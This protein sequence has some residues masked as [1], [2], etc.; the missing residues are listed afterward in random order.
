[1]IGYVTRTDQT[2]PF[3]IPGQD[4]DIHSM[5]FV[6]VPNP[7]W[8]GVNLAQKNIRRDYRF[9]A[10]SR[11]AYLE[12]A[13]GNRTALAGGGNNRNVITSTVPATMPA[14]DYQVV[15]VDDGT[16]AE[17]VMGVTLT[18][19]TA[20]DVGLRPNGGS[21]AVHRVAGPA[22]YPAT[23]IQDAID[24]AAPGDLVLVPPGS[25]EELVVMWKP[26]RLQ[27][28]G[29]GEVYLNARQFPAEKIT[30][31]RNKVANLL[32][33]GS[34]DQLLGQA[35]G[36]PGFPALTEA[37]FPTEEGAAIFVAGKETGPNRFGRL[38]N[39]FARIDGMTLLGAS[40]GGG[41]IVNGYAQFL[42]IANNR[43]MG[44]AGSFGGGIRVGHPTL[45]HPENGV[46]V[47]DDA[48]N[49]N[50]RIHHN[51]VVKN[52]SFVGDG[53]GISLYTG[54][55][56]YRVQD[57]MICGNYT[58]GNGA[59]VA[60][61]GL[62]RNGL[63]E[64]NL[65]V[66]NE[67]FA[68]ANAQSG[69]GV[70]VG[71]KPGLEPNGQG[72]LLSTGSGSVTID[73]N[74]IRG[75]MAGAGDGGGIRVAAANGDDIDASLGDRSGWYVVRVFNNMITNNV[76]GLAGGGM[77]VSDSLRVI[78]RNNTIANN[79][80]TATTAEAFVPGMANLTVAQPAGIVS[81][82]HSGDMLALMGDVTDTVP[83]DW[84]TFS[85]PALRDNIVYQNRSFYWT[86][87]DDPNTVVIESGLVPATCNDPTDPLNDPTC[88]IDLVAVADYTD[89]LGVLSALAPTAQLDPRFSLLTDDTGY[90]ASNIM[91]DPAFVNGYLNG[92]RYV[93]PT[94]PEFK[95][96][97]TAGAFDEGGNF[98]QVVFKP[99]TLGDFDYHI[100]AG[101]AA[102][103]AGASTPATGRLSVDYDNDARPPAAGASD[104]GADEAQ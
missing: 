93:L 63:I 45:N 31:W 55:D 15:V 99:L 68:Q 78:V 100:G 8:D 91:G 24:A 18:V 41:V 26:V 43:V 42:Q 38:A 97:Q 83:A 14:G 23:P 47:H 101:S 4:I 98:I 39:R 75:N 37:I 84:L 28:W 20:E 79:D 90:H 57:N 5:G 96:L 64:D 16:G 11:T 22:P 59:G 80:S 89:D 10:G 35:I 69:G 60:H 62:S 102:I 81:R 66:F 33:D 40:T 73:A 19:G 92:S 44:N 1:M 34:I 25:Y 56:N 46:L 48:I 88:D 58:Q 104:I 52:G 30:T 6:D 2:G 71:G 17:T 85:D 21:F 76:A 54:T 29:A 67:S 51:H 65:I 103:D 32:A 49:D 36:I 72:R 3:V 50:I 7:D 87:Y 61:F 9:L 86:N 74:I 12:D 82:E 27:G 53:G 94:L 95:T 70:F 77:S 13:N